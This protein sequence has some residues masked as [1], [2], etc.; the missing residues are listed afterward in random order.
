M[1]AVREVE[2]SIG[3]PG[4]GQD[5]LQRG[6]ALCDL[7]RASEPR[8][9]S[10]GSAFQNLGPALE[11]ELATLADGKH[12]G[13]HLRLFRNLDV[14]VTIEIDAKR[15]SPNLLEALRV[16]PTV[17]ATRRPMRVE[18]PHERS[19]LLALFE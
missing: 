3:S 14:L 13:A 6:I 12:Q 11:D 9:A 2:C 1:A 7:T 4:V 15:G 19:R 18:I 16:D 17:Q 10:V 8:R 5:L